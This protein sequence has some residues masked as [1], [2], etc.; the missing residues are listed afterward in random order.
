[1]TLAPVIVKAIKD[2]VEASLPSS[3]QNLQFLTPGGTR[4]IF[5][6]D[7]GPAQEK[8]VIKVDIEPESP[9]AKRHVSRGYD[10]SNDIEKLA[11][12]K[13]P[14]LHGIMGLVDY[15]EEGGLTIS[16]EKFFEGKNLEERVKEKPL[17]L[18]EFTEVFSQVADIQRYLIN[19][20]ELYHRDAKPSNYLID[21]KNRVR[22]TDFANAGNKED[23]EAKVMPSAGGHLI[24]K[25]TTF[26]VFTG[27]TA[28]HSESDEVYSIGVNMYFALTGKY[29]FEF[30]PDKKTATHVESG[31][32]LLDEN[33]ILDKEKYAH[34]LTKAVKKL[35]K[36]ARK[37]YGEVIEKSLSI[38]EKQGYSSITEFHK[39]FHYA[40]RTSGWFERR[41]GFRLAHVATFLA[42]A[43]TALGM[44]QLNENAKQ[45][46]VALEQ[47]IEDNKRY[48]VG[49]EWDGDKLE[50]N[51][52][53]FEPKIFA[54]I[55]KTE[56]RF[57]DQEYLQTERGGKVDISITL[58]QIAR[59]ADLLDRSSITLKGRAYIEGLKEFDDF[60]M[61]TH[62][63]DG[64]DMQGE[65]AWGGIGS[66]RLD[67]PKN[68]P[69]G[70]YNIMIEVYA[71]TEEDLSNTVTANLSKYRFRHPGR[72]LSRKRIPI[73]VGD[74]KARLIVNSAEPGYISSRV[75][76][77]C[78][79]GGTFR[80]CDL[81]K[82]LTM[83][84]TLLNS[85]KTEKT[86]CGNSNSCTNFNAV[87]NPEKEGED[88]LRV[89]IKDSAGTTQTYGYIPVI[90]EKVGDATFVGMKF[91]IP[92]YKL[93][94]QI[95]KEHQDYLRQDQSK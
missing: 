83:F 67:I 52:N 37:K 34:L 65:G 54:Y 90:G 12:I 27:E 43:G 95:A 46:E 29:L 66:P 18:D 88:L 89:V 79:G 23:L 13:E 62:S 10:T 84:T 6:A 41:I 36:K 72:I 40:K 14:E 59:G 2:K 73:V 30:D 60:Q 9:R 45:A 32:N 48:L 11:H 5:T 24:L 53:L 22:I 1:M 56:S 91:N 47:Q 35:P 94:E 15:I 63:H 28:A 87:G 4:A 25:P 31:E 8:R 64:R 58:K 51:N 76:A 44:A 3:Y 80:S 68:L 50:I 49:A 19:T 69:D 81:P 42:L 78:L 20:A 21:D 26:S 70:N 74:P 85:G 17:T 82:D 16:V 61:W 93:Q 86:P 33:G 39:D 38:D 92:G 57:P 71:P 55:P 7:W 77:S 75:Y